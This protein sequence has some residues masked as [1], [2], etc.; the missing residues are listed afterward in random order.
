MHSPTIIAAWPRALSGDMDGA[1]QDRDKAVQLDPNN[2]DARK[3]LEAVVAAKGQSRPA[4]TESTPDLP[5]VVALLERGDAYYKKRKYG[6]AI[7]EY[8]RAVALAPNEPTTYSARA[9]AR[10]QKGEYDGALDDYSKAIELDPSYVAAY[11]GRALTLVKKREPERAIADL[12]PRD[13][14]ETGPGLVVF[15]TRQRPVLY[16][17]L[18]PRHRRFRPGRLSSTPD[19]K[20]LGRLGS[21][22]WRRREKTSRRQGLRQRPRPP[23]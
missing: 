6:R 21:W 14:D 4:D 3:E 17:R 5:A 10:L 1:H 8:S 23:T 22:R 18:R 2:A 20:M 13:C 12:R 19:T 16:G 11:N 9:L 15:R 7:A